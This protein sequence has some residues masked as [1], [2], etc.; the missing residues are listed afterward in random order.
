MFPDILLGEPLGPH[1]GHNGDFIGDTTFWPPR[2]SWRIERDRATFIRQ[3]MERD[4]SPVLDPLGLGNIEETI[5]HSMRD[6]I[7]K[8]IKRNLDRTPELIPRDSNL[9]IP[10]PHHLDH[11]MEELILG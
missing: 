4:R 9:G 11:P 3:G 5:H 8:L 7:I 2:S 6:H 10:S 1:L